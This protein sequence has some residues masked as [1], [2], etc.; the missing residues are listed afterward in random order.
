M[1]LHKDQ[2]MQG[3]QAGQQKFAKSADF[4]RFPVVENTYTYIWKN[5]PVTSHGYWWLTSRKWIIANKIK[6][7]VS[8]IWTATTVLYFSTWGTSAQILKAIRF[9]F[10][11]YSFTRGQPPISVSGHW[12]ILSR[13]RIQIPESL[14]SYGNLTSLVLEI[15]SLVFLKINWKFNFPMNRSVSLLVCLS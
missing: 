14:W 12:R 6:R 3:W 13:I 5:T 8:K 2:K 1:P 15:I 9:L 10:R 7:I 11:K 4:C